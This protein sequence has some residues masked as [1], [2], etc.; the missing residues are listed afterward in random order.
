MRSVALCSAYPAYKLKA[1]DLTI[2][3]L[4]ELTVYNMRKLFAAQVRVKVIHQG[5][6]CMG[7]WDHRCFISSSCTLSH[8]KY[9]NHPHMHQGTDFM[10]YNKQF[11]D[12]CGKNNR[13][14]RIV[15]GTID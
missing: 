2:A 6:S 7:L 11:S 8:F 3:R 5:G 4:S 15:S 9:N 12:D 13:K 10:D 1:A 14:K